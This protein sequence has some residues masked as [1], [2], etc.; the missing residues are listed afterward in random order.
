MTAP[1][2]TAAPI[3][4][5][6]AVN[7]WFGTGELRKQILFDVSLEL[8]PGEVVL[9][10]GQSGS[11]KTTLLTLMGALRSLTAGSL[12]VF[13]QELLHAST[14][15]Q[16]QIRRRIGFIFQA[17]NLIPYLSALDNVRLA[18]ELSPAV[19]AHEGRQRAAELLTAVGLAERMHALPAQLSGGQKQRVA[20]ARAMVNRPGLIL[21]DEPTS[22]LDRA[23][24]REVIERL[25]ALARERGMPIVVVTHD[26]R[27]FD[28]ADRSIDL[29][30]GRVL[31]SSARMPSGGTHE[32][33]RTLDAAA[34]PAE[35][36]LGRWSNA[37]P[38]EPSAPPPAPAPPPRRYEHIS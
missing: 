35:S 5:A 29:E 18:L 30:D 16:V 32:R 25:V 19:T 6:R 23:T 7:F 4:Q 15:T 27:I 24:G 3:V 31:P 14:P 13:G 37:P 12:R 17:H 10:T 8:H 9:L 22:A 34:A 11:G 1:T 38:T 33:S 21:A 28:V 2:T 26:S 20:I 36:R